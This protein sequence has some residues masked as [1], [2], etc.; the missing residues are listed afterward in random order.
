MQIYQIGSCTFPCITRNGLVQGVM[1][2]IMAV[3]IYFRMNDSIQYLHIEVGS[4]LRFLA[5]MYCGFIWVCPFFAICTFL[6]LLP[7]YCIC[8]D[9]PCSPV[10][11]VWPTGYKEI[12]ECLG[13]P[14][15]QQLKSWFDQIANVLG[16]S[17]QV[18]Y[19]TFILKTCIRFYYY[20]ISRSKAEVYAEEAGPDGIYH[21]VMDI[22][23]VSRW[24][25]C[26]VYCL[27]SCVCSIMLWWIRLMQ[28]ITAWYAVG[29][30]LS[31]AQ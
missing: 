8:L 7:L 2:V 15:E 24:Q 6:S 10:T 14:F 21:Y 20:R 19:I 5:R 29:F 25:N 1:I 3:A 27:P 12:G 30:H 4:Q 28:Q 22:S 11:A 17:V 9:L 16:S 31:V 18:T 23:A 13:H 26:Q